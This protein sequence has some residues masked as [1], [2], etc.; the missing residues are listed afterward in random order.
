MNKRGFTLIELL[1]VIAIIGILAAILL[2]ALARAREAARRSSCA[3]NLKQWGLIF[4]MYAGEDPGQKYPPVQ[5]ARPQQLAVYATPF[6]TGVYPE[7]VT[8]PA[9][10]VC[11]S[12]AEHTV[13][14]MYYA[15]ENRDD[16]T[17]APE[18]LGLSILIDRRRTADAHNRWWQADDS[19]VY[20]GFI[21]D[22]CDVVEE[23]GLMTPAS[24]Y[25]FL[26]SYLPDGVTIPE[27]ELV[28]K[29]FV[30]HWV[31]MIL[32][33]PAMEWISHMQAPTN[34]HWHFGPLSVLDRDT[35][36]ERLGSIECGNGGGDTIYRLCDGAERFTIHD[37]ADPSATTMAQSEIFVMFDVVSAS[38]ADFNHVP[39]GAN[40]LYMDGHVAFVKY[41]STRAPVL[42]S[43]ALAMQI[44]NPPD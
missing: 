14:L 29:Q 6:V 44:L 11:P 9:I 36:S 16:A 42:R 28:P 27:G 4:K 3:N 15:A 26:L 1:V 31:E 2:P 35:K 41:P 30:E 19:Y 40:V 10:Y 12:S 37:V 7:Y 17:F 24:D 43:F 32:Y 23:G 21:Y 34:K 25:N 8:D 5:H 18:A 38:A 22:R 33:D 20:F 13:E 39:G